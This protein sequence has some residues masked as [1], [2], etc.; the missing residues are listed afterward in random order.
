M[1][2]PR[3]A[4]PRE[5]LRAV[6]L[7]ILS[8]ALPLLLIYFVPTFCLHASTVPACHPHRID[9][10]QAFL[11]ARGASESSSCCRRSRI[12]LDCWAP[13]LLVCCD[14]AYELR[15]AQSVVIAVNSAGSVQF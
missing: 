1:G 15:V 3:A 7:G 2:G 11:L 5:A 6:E 12:F 8:M 13:G 4:V 14:G 10:L 9:H